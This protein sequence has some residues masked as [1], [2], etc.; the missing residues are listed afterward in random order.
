MSTFDNQIRRE[1]RERS[2]RKWWD[3]NSYKVFRMILFPV[4]LF[5]LVRERHDTYLR[6]KAA[7]SKERAKA[8]LDKYL[9][10]I[11][12]NELKYE[13]DGVLLTNSDD[14]GYQLGFRT[15]LKIPRRKRKDIIFRDKFFP[16]ILEYLWNE[17]EIEGWTAVRLQNWMDWD[18]AERKYGWVT[19]WNKDYAK[20]VYFKREQTHNET[21]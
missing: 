8:L 5:I 3:N 7:F 9:P 10:K 4:W 17:Y 15:D 6:K 14:F 2:V 19:C 1:S 16:Q 20:G 18:R 11:F 13:S 21:Y 12:A